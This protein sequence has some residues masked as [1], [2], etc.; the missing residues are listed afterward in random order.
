M[1]ILRCAG[2]NGLVTFEANYGHGGVI[3]LS[4]VE[5]VHGFDHYDTPRIRRET[6]TTRG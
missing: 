6:S 1:N 5:F 4:M 2:Y 3:E